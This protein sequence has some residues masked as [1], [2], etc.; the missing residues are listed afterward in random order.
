MKGEKKMQNKNKLILQIEIDFNSE[1][2]KAMEL[3]DNGNYIDEISE[4]LTA[5]G[6]EFAERLYV[7]IVPK[8]V[9]EFIKLSEDRK[10]P[11]K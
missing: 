10:I 8:G 2:K 1:K 6:K 5:S 11:G 4:I 9:R 3:Y 7:K